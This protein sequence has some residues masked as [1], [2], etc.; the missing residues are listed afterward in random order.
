MDPEALRRAR[1]VSFAGATLEIAGREDFVAMKA[2]VGGPVDLA[3][4][5]AVIDLDRGSLD[6]ELLRR[7]AQRFGRE[8]VKA[9]EELIGH[10]D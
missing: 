3:D 8:T 7:L 1:Q 6:V 5:R 2:F 9:V 10:A 4:A